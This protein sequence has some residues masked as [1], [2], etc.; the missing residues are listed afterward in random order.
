MDET[1]TDTT[2]PYALERVPR[3]GSQILV[4]VE[5]GYEGVSAADLGLRYL[6]LSWL[7]PSRLAEFIQGFTKA[8]SYPLPPL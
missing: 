2:M 4:T 6:F 3:T 8:E 5:P 1:I 7:E